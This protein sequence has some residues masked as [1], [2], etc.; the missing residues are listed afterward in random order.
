MSTVNAYKTDPPKPPLI[1]FSD[2]WGRHPSSSQHLVSHLL[3]DFEVT[4]ID[5]IGMRRP[6][7]D[8][9]TVRRGWEKL[10]HWS[11]RRSQPTPQT[12][13]APRVLRPLMW[14]S[15]RS[16]AGRGVNRRLL[17]K[18][19]RRSVP[20]W[21]EATVL[22]TIPIVA[23]LPV[24]LPVKRWV[25][26]C[27]DDFSTWP[28]LDSRTLLGMEEKFVAEADAIVA[29]S[30]VLIERVRQLGREATLLTHGVDLA[31]WQ[32]AASASECP[33][34][35]ARLEAPRALFWGLIDR[36][37]D[38]AFLRR[39]AESLDR[40][41]IVLAGPQQNPD[42]ALD[43]LPRTHRIGPVPFAQLPQLAAASDVLIMPYADLPVTRA[44]QPL[45]LKEYLAT[46]KPVVCTNLPAVQDWRDALD[47]ADEPQAFARLVAKRAAD[48][49]PSAHQAARARLAGESWL[50]KAMQLRAI[51]MNDAT[52]ASPA[53]RE[54]AA[55]SS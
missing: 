34:P 48:G 54:T 41:S 50:A 26:Y 42:P 27:V 29:V 39:L 8:R 33:D 24:R 17:A 16:A 9:Q 36:R 30:E 45:K 22:S 25:Y 53:D 37:L 38:I 15:F 46:G 28:G 7:L 3:D 31:H 52:C 11:P 40:G 12:A 18:M 32:A 23:D 1:V 5:T 49:L 21:Q 44:M 14:P 43:H 4:W 20:R 35:F 47:V 2:D 6:R 13:D 55:C 10:T 51:L 19:L